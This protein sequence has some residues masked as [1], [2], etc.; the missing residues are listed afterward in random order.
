MCV[1]CQRL[2]AGSAL[3]MAV[4]AVCTSALNAVGTVTSGLAEEGSRSRLLVGDG[5]VSSY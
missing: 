4:P 5:A 2:W 1:S 3:P